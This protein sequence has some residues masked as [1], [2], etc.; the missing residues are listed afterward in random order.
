MLRFNVLILLLWLVEKTDAFPNRITE[1]QGTT[2]QYD[3]TKYHPISEISAWMG[4]I[5]EEN[6]GVVTSSVFGQTFE[7]RNMTFLKI[8]VNPGGKQKKAVWIDCGIHARE[9]IAPAFCQWFVKEI[10][11]TFKT[12]DKLNKMVQNL[13]FYVMPVFNIDGYVYSW[14]N[15][16]TRLWRKSRSAP[17]DSC[18]CYGVDLNRNFDALWGTV[19]VSSDCCAFNYPGTAAVSEKESQALT[20]FLSNRTDEI[21][22][23]FTIHSYGQQILLPYG[24]PHVS[25][26]NYNE[27]MEVGLASAKAMKSVHGMD[28]EVGSSAAILYPFSGNSQ[29]WV[30]L[31]GIPF[32]F[33]FEL[34]DKGEFAFELPEDQIQPVCEEVY[35]GVYHIIRYIHDKTFHNGVDSGAAS[36]S[37]MLWTVVMVPASLWLH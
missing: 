9:W 31:I 10:L 2:L 20:A 6:P 19:G 32:S 22:C 28:Y 8:S 14:I 13:D 4:Q 35:V 17:P 24:H 16:T 26:P 27:L 11:R 23:Y 5:V 15:E 18:D 3:Y 7:G 21:L 36:Y 29:D 34:R 1:Q 12:D 33:T 37:L 25:V 30:R